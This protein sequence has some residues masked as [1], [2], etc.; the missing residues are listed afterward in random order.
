[1]VRSVVE[2]AARRR[3]LEPSTERIR[4]VEEPHLRTLVALPYEVPQR[5]TARGVPADVTEDGDAYPVVDELLEEV[6]GDARSQLEELVLQPL[7]RDGHPGSFVLPRRGDEIVR[8]N[9]VAKG[10]PVG[11]AQKDRRSVEMLEGVG[12][13]FCSVWS[14]FVR[15][16][17]SLRRTTAT[18]S[19]L[20]WIRD[21]T[22]VAVHGMLQSDIGVSLLA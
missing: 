3:L 10:P 8:V 22:L 20:H 5:V 9:F 15:P 11:G 16:R 12:N 21:H 4:V 2:S 7:G 19:D 18:P 14:L 13:R 6:A 17:G 1:M